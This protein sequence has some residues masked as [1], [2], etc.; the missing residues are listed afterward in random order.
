[1]V[2]PILTGSDRGVVSVYLITNSA[3]GSEWAWDAEKGASVCTI[4]GKPAGKW[5]PGDECE[6]KQ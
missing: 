3:D 2:L 6:C 4:K 1:M 5:Q